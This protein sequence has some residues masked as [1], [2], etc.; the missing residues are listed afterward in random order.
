M[1]NMTRRT[2]LGS[3]AAA[4]AFGLAAKLEF[5]PPA[6]AAA[7]VEPAVGFYRYKVGIDRGHRH[8]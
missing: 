7:P 2:V 1:F 5:I 8:L 3:A 4:A 6:F